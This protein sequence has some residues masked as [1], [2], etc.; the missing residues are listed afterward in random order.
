MLAFNFIINLV[1]VYKNKLLFFFFILYL[2]VGF[3]FF[4][5]YKNYSFF[6]LFYNSNFYFTFDIISSFFF[7]LLIIIRRFIIQYSFWY[8]NIE[9]RKGVFIINII[10]FIFFIFI[11]TSARNVL[12]LVLRWERVGIM[13]FFLIRW[14]FRRR[15]ATIC[16]SQAIYYNRLGDFCILIFILLINIRFFFL[17][18]TNT[19]YNTIFLLVCISIIAKSSQILFHSWLPNAIEGPTPVSSLLHSSTIVVAR[20]FLLIRLHRYISNN[21]SILPPI[22][23]GLTILFIRICSSYQSDIKKIIAY[24]TSSQL[25]FII[26]TVFYVSPQIRF[27]LLTTHSFFKSILFL[28]SRLLIHN[29]NNEQN[30]LR[31]NSIE[32]NKRVMFSFYISSLSL[33]RMPYFSRFFSKDIIIENIWRN[34]INLYII[35]VF[36][37]GCVFTV[38]YSMNLINSIRFCINTKLISSEKFAIELIWLPFITL[39]GIFFRRSMFFFFLNYE[40]LFFFKYLIYFPIIIIIIR[41][42]FYFLIKNFLYSIIF[43]YVFFFNPIIH[44]IISGNWLYSSLHFFLLDYFLFEY[45]ILFAK[46]LYKII[47]N[48]SLLK[49]YKNIIILIILIFLFINIYLI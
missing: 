1:L 21:I 2:F 41:S 28:R 33:I 11:L 37:W 3:F 23:R 48:L 4:I 49:R 26:F 7:F 32:R 16:A 44:S 40:E 34:V 12:M 17:K 9:P 22:L 29:N 27:F 10:I 25:R 42:I 35:I 36:F 30:I 6:F 39:R 18:N 5:F 43:K 45:I 46:Y 24:S 31:L 8:I 20:V 38:V 19:I 14:W 47:K 15:E 13:S